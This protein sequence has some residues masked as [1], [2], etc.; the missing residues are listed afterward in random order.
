MGSVEVDARRADTRKYSPARHDVDVITGNQFGNVRCVPT[1]AV[2]CKVD[3]ESDL[4]VAN[5]LFP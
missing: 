1:K 3:S 2:W 4:K 5:D